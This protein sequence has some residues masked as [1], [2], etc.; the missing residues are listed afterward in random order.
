MAQFT[1]YRNK[2]PSTQPAIP[3]LLDI[4]SDLLESLETRVV[5]PLCP[6]GAV[7]GKAMRTL[8]P[9]L[10]IEGEPFMMLTPQLAG[11][12]RSELGAPIARIQQQRFTIIAAI[13]FLVTGI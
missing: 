10:E 2:N 7:R 12:C 11:V 8:T 1:V 13:D 3:Y 9:V 5:V 4:Q 6:P